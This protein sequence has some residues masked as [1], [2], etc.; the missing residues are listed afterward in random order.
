MTREKCLVTSA[1]VLTMSV[2]AVVLALVLS[3]GPAVASSTGASG[4]S[5]PVSC[6]PNWNMVNTSNPRTHHY[7]NA[8]DV[9]SAN[10]IWAV[11]EYYS[12]QNYTLDTEIAMHLDCVLWIMVSTL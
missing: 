2:F 3:A 11:G 7:L 1:I 8:I 4:V 5:A 6:P 10:D 12:E 9:I